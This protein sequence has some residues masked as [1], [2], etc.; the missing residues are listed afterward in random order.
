MARPLAMLAA[1][2]A[3][4]AYDVPGEASG[5]A[6]AA[7]KTT[8]SWASLARADGNGT[9][10]DV[11]RGDLGALRS[12]GSIAAAPCLGASTTSTTRSDPQTPDPGPGVY[13]LLQARNACGAGGWGT[14]SSGAP[15]THGSCP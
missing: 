8:L 10:Y 15:R 12:G 5:L 3:G 9:V 6:F 11:V 4:G 14:A 7:D 13:Y 2:D 1:L